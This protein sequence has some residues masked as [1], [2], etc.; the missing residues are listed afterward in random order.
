MT[1]KDGFSTAE[2]AAMRQ[3]AEELQSQK[4]VKG[5]AKK[6]KELQ[7]CLDAIAELDGTDRTVAER[8][9]VIVT[10]EAPHLDPKTWYG[11]PSYALDGAVLTFVQ[12]AAKF[13]TRY[14]TVAFNDVAQLDDGA[15][16]PTAYAVV[17]WTAAVEKTLRAAV[18]KGTAG[19]A[20]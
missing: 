8:F 14:P 3:R 15:M 5:A 6:A 2:R 1:D 12:P 7:A 4:G 11:F 10:E 13:D 16:W 19:T 17:E 18:R 20:A 9:H